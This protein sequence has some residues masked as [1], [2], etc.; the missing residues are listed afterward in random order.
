VDVVETEDLSPEE[1]KMYSFFMASGLTFLHDKVL[2]AHNDL[3]LSQFAV[4]KKG[5]PQTLVLL[6]F[7]FSSDINVKVKSQ[8][9]NVNT[10]AYEE[11]ENK[12]YFPGPKDAFGIG[13]IIY[14]LI[15]N[16]FPFVIKKEVDPF[17]HADGSIDMDGFIKAVQSRLK[18]FEYDLESVKEFDKDAGDFIDKL[19]Q[20]DPT[21]R[22]KAAEMLHHPYLASM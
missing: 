13:L 21:D 10:M 3:S 2:R 20:K 11:L 8:D 18:R 4:A 16:H 1:V 19:I 17:F 12:E 15:E 5:R 9:C 6:D 7:A 14:H 22:L